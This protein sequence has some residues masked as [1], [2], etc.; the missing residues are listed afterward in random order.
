VTTEKAE[1]EGNKYST[2]FGVQSGVAEDS[3]LLGCDAV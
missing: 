1:I 2:K 3:S